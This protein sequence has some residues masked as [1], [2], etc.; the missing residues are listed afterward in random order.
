LKQPVIFENYEAN[1]EECD[2]FVK[3]LLL[4]DN[5]PVASDPVEGSSRDQ[6]DSTFWRWYPNDAAD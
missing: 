6:T 4:D 1:A 5:V 2:S 3:C